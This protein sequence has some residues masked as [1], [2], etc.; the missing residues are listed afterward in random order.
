MHT[1]LYYFMLHDSALHT[2]MFQSFLT[3]GPEQLSCAM[4]EKQR[5]RSVLRE[6]I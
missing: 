4:R 5:S 3:D 1:D 6:L 2:A